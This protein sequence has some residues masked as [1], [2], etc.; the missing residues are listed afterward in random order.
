MLE[1]MLESISIDAR[2]IESG[3]T[4][5]EHAAHTGNLALA[6]LCYRRGANLNAKALSGDTPFTIACKNKRYFDVLFVRPLSTPC[7]PLLAV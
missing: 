4:L 3:R 5:L 1:R 7:A 2:D 6:K